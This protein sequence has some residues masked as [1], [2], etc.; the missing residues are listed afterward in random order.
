MDVERLY[1]VE[2]LREAS[3]FWRGSGDA[4]TVAFQRVLYSVYAMR[5]QLA[6]AAY[7]H[8]DRESKLVALAA[9]QAAKMKLWRRIFGRIA[10]LS[11]AFRGDWVVAQS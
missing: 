7:S 4:K 8:R 5:I 11:R 1:A 9:P 3:P 2:P 6:V 10:L